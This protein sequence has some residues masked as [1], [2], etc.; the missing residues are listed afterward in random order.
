M[1][2]RLY[3][4]LHTYIGKALMMAASKGFPERIL[5]NLALCHVML[6]QNQKPAPNILTAQESYFWIS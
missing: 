2:P 4:I 5:G 1:R 3:V 6:V